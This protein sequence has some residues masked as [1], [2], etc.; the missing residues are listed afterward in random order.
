MMLKPTPPELTMMILS[1]ELGIDMGRFQQRTSA[2]TVDQT[3]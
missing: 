2:L 3:T 1:I